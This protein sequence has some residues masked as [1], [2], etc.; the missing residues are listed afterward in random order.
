MKIRSRRLIRF[1]ARIV[2]ACA[3]RLFATV[4]L[5]IEMAVPDTCA[6]RD[7]G[8]ERFL[9]CLWHDAILGVIFG[10]RPVK[11]AGLVSRHTD[12][13]YVADI[14]ESVGLTP[15]RGSSQRGGEAALRRM[16]DAA[17]EYHIA[18]TT[19]GPRGPRHVVKEGIVFL[20]SRTGRPIVPAAIDATRAWRPR[21]RWTDML[22]PKPYSRM[23]LLIGE[24][25][26]VPEDAD[27]EAREALRQELQR[28]MDALTAEARRRASCAA[29]APA[30]AS[31]I[32]AERRAA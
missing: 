14:M 28:R 25:L 10:D 13:S 29:T 12:G 15:I 22:I 3:R 26:H 7:T 20:A 5:D 4:R 9:Y 2:A 24:P 17:A 8:G 23:T 11:M 32:P 31:Q 19:D 21:G 27:R 16:I 1:A 6:Y 18:I 30:A